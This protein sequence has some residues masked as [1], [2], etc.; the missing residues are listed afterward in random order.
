MYIVMYV[1][2]FI[3]IIHDNMYKKSKGNILISNFV[4][5]KFATIST[6]KVQN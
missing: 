5:S 4:V 1:T 2:I 3:Y 6:K